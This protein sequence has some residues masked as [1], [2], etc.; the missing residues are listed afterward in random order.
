MKDEVARGRNRLPEL[1]LDLTSR[2]GTHYREVDD[3][4]SAHQYIDEHQPFI[5]SG[6]GLVPYCGRQCLLVGG[7]QDATHED[8][9]LA[10]DWHHEEKQQAV[11]Q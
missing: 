6:H 1:R 10:Q 4:N 7:K 11:P 9:D 2:P 5:A 8:R 3:L